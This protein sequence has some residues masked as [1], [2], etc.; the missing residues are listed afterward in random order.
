M[1]AAPS[2]NIEELR[3]WIG[4]SETRTDTVTAAPVVAMSATL[5]TG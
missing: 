4:R 1:S 2:L 3:Q 5:D